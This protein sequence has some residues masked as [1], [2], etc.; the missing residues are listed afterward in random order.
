MWNFPRNIS[1]YLVSSRKLRAGMLVSFGNGDSY[2]ILW[3]L[4]MGNISISNPI[5]L[6]PYIS[7]I[8]KISIVLL[9]ICDAKY[10][11]NTVYIDANC[12]QSDGDVNG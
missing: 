1:N 9:G 3:V 10:K 12:R 11:L 5:Y 8:K 6:T 7:T 2:Q 4:W